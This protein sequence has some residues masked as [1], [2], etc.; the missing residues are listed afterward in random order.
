MLQI[1]IS[2]AMA[3]APNLPPPGCSDWCR[4]A[5]EVSTQNLESNMLVWK[6]AALCWFLAT[7][8]VLVLW[9]IDVKKLKLKRGESDGI[10]KV[11]ERNE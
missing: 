8:L 1:N 5:F 10:N 2:Q 3:Q 9:Y 4:Q 11:A 7:L 6:I